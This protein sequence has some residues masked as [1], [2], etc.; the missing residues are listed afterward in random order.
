MNLSCSLATTPSESEVT[1]NR[2]PER[3]TVF[4]GGGGGITVCAPAVATTHKSENAITAT[5]IHTSM[6]VMVRAPRRDVLIL[7]LKSAERRV[8]GGPGPQAGERRC[9]DVRGGADIQ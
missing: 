9:P 5:R 2:G 6:T 8:S 7:T 4:A 1:P 3:L